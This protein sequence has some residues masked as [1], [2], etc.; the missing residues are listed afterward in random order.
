MTKT[1]ARCRAIVAATWSNHHISTES[2]PAGFAVTVQATV[3]PLRGMT[4]IASIGA[5]TPAIAWRRLLAE[6]KRIAR[7]EIDKHEGTAT[8]RA[9]EALR[10]RGIACDLR[11]LLYADVPS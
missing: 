8:A 7:M 6:L 10:H 11:A 3:P 1:E 2:A 5:P 4:R 9:N